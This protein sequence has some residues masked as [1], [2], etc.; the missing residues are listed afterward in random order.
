MRILAMV[1]VVG[2]AVVLIIGILGIVEVAQFGI[3]PLI[4]ALVG[5]L[6]L[7]SGII[8]NY[9]CKRNKLVNEE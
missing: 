1:M 2:G 9:F 4:F 3:D 6:T 5:G 8:L 7:I